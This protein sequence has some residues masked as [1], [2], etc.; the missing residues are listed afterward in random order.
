VPSP[1]LPS[2]PCHWMPN[3][4][5]LSALT[6]AIRLSTY[7]C[8]RRASSLSITARSWRY[9][10]SG[11]VMMSEL[12]AGSAWICPP[13]E[14]WLLALLE[15]RRA[16]PGL[17]RPARPAGLADAVWTTRRRPPEPEVAAAPLGL[18]GRHGRMAR[19][20]WRP[21]WWRRRSSGTPHGC[22]R[23]PRCCR[24]GGWSS[25]STSARTRATRAGLAA[26]RIRVLLRGSAI[27]V[28]LNEVSLWPGPP[29]GRLRCH[30][31][32]AAPPA[33]PGRRPRR[34]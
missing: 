3:S 5:A 30:R 7:T 2:T 17:R 13:V 29:P 22:C 24:T 9:C 25:L 27:S 21:A 12:V 18:V 8:A 6:S 14:G 4:A 11:A 10:G 20:A 32:S 34:A 19:A 26:R 1:F 28:V 23:W 15:C 33:G 16:C 31:Q